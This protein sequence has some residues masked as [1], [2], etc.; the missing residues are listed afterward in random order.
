MCEVLNY[1]EYLPFFSFYSYWMFPVDI[2][3]SALGLKTSVTTVG[4]KKY[5][6]ITMKKDIS[7]DITHDKF[8]SINLLK[9]CYGMK[10]EIKK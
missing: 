8:F 9:E 7:S 1:I 6:I 5:K 3:S 4:N 10:E 2:T